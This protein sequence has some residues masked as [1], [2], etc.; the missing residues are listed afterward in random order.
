MLPGECVGVDG[1]TCQGF[2][3]HDPIKLEL[4]VLRSGAGYYVGYFCPKC[5]PFSRESG[6]FATDA[7]AQ[8]EM[9]AMQN[10]GCSS[11]V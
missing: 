6:Y 2:G 8:A 1:V 3:D 5:G 4:S 10:Q 11:R 7:D 9:K